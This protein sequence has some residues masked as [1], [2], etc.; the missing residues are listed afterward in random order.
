MTVIH[1][2]FSSQ[3][4]PILSEHNRANCDV[5]KLFLWSKAFST[6]VTPH[7]FSSGPDVILL[8]LNHLHRCRYTFQ[9][10][11][12]CVYYIVMVLYGYGCNE[13]LIFNTNFVF[14]ATYVSH[15]QQLQA[16]NDQTEVHRSEIYSSV[17]NYS[18]RNSWFLKH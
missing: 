11:S 15:L 12:V 17:V 13:D 2:I 5:C 1:T 3:P 10:E 4:V 18:R 16:Q 9:K 6:E 7:Q 14:I 8:S